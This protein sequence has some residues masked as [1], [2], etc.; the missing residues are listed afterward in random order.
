VEFFEHAPLRSRADVFGDTSPP[1]AA[2]VYAWYFDDIP[3]VPTDDCFNRDGRALLYV[4]ISPGPPSAAGKESRENLFKRIRYHY[5]GVNGYTGNA[6]GS[7]LRLTLGSL[8][9]EQLGIALRRVGSGSRMTFAHEGEV[10]LSR[11]MAAHAS[12]CWDE[13]PA[14]WI[15]E[16]RLIASGCFPLNLRGNPHP[17]AAAVAAKR[18]DQRTIAKAQSVVP[19]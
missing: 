6:Y 12:V 10:A 3:G 8:L 16:K 15:E 17:F 2:G 4:G 7:T 1:K 9:A 13:T 11:W 5:G 18:A 14:P 19:A